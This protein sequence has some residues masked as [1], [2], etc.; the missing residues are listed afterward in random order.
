ML[1]FLVASQGFLFFVLL[2]SFQSARWHK[3]L[4]ARAAPKDK[5]V[6]VIGCR[7]QGVGRLIWCLIP[8]KFDQHISFRGNVS[9]GMP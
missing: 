9:S 4:L 5:G 8:Q 1:S 2:C 6:T 3:A 7:V